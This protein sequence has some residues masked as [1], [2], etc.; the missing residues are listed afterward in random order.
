V[1]YPVPAERVAVVLDPDRGS[2]GGPEGVDAEQVGQ[3]AVV[4]A[5]GLR[6]LQEPDQLEPVQSVGAGLIGVDLR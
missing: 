4:H 6:D 3:G 2:L 1:Q 5:D